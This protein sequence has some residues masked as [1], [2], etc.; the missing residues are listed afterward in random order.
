MA[1]LSSVQA[2]LRSCM[3]RGMA[4]PSRASRCLSAPG[5]SGMGGKTTPGMSVRLLGWLRR[6][7]SIRCISY[8]G[9]IGYQWPRCTRLDQPTFGP[10]L[11]V[12]LRLSAFGLRISTWLGRDAQGSNTV[13]ARERN[14]KC[15][16]RNAECGVTVRL[17]AGGRVTG[18]SCGTAVKGGRARVRPEEMGRLMFGA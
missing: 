1:G 6:L 10:R 4:N 18:V 11:S 3:W 2:T 12:F 5:S 7:S 16:V 13:E 17:G 8:M 14:P 9:Y 15:G